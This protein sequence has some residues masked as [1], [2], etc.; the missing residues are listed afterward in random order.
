V[1]TLPINLAIQSRYQLPEASGAYVIGVIESLPAS[2]AGLPP[3]S[4]IVAFDNRPVRSPAEL[5]SLVT[6]SPPGR[7]VA[8]QYVLPGG[9]SHQA[10]VELQRIDPALEEALVGVPITATQPTGSIPRT[11]QR[12]PT[13]PPALALEEV[14]MLTA[15]VNMLRQEVLRLRSRLDQLEGSQPAPDRVRGALTR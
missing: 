1:R 3:G 9:R 14:H 5:N 12:L 13:Q 4:V 7:L 10:E 8:V 2:Q 11:A 15:E 6:G